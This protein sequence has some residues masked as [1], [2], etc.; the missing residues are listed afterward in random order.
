LLASNKIGPGSYQAEVKP[1]V[2]RV[3]GALSPQIDLQNG[4]RFSKERRFPSFDQKIPGP[5]T[6]NDLA[7]WNKRTYN[8]RFLKI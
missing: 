5:G 2:M 6:Y 3:G 1:S 8:L 7:Q 4:T